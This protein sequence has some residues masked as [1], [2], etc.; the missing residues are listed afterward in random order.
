M[1]K[2]IKKCVFVLFQLLER[3]SQWCNVEY[4]SASYCEMI[5]TLLQLACHVSDVGMNSNCAL[6]RK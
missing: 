3:S 5:V 2:I 4:G 6:N 1:N